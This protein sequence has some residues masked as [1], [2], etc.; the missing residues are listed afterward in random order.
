MSVH[1][2]AG[3]LMLIAVLSLAR[4]VRAEHPGG[5][6]PSLRISTGGAL[7]QLFGEH[8]SYGIKFLQVTDATLDYEFCITSE[9]RVFMG[10]YLKVSFFTAP[11]FASRIAGGLVTGARVSAKLDL[12]TEIGLGRA[13][14]DIMNSAHFGQT[15]A[16]YDLTLGLRHHLPG[17]LSL[18]AGVTHESN[19]YAQGINFFIPASQDH[20]RFNIG[21]TYLWLGVGW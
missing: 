2:R 10:P 11:E 21:I 12:F 19:G 14:Q 6:H 8:D 13:T 16:T 15:A 3:L 4:P 7:G 1:L 20:A 5:F 9:C 18:L 17:R